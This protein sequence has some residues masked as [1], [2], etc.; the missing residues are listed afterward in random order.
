MDLRRA[1]TRRGWDRPQL[2][3]C[4]WSSSSIAPQR[5]WFGPR[6]ASAAGDCVNGGPDTGTMA[7]VPGK[8]TPNSAARDKTDANPDSM[9]PRMASVELSRLAMCRS[10]ACRPA[11]SSVVSITSRVPEPRRAS[12]EARRRSAQRGWSAAGPSWLGG[13][14]QHSSSSSQISERTG[15]RAVGPPPGQMDRGRCNGVCD[16]TRCCCFELHMYRGSGAETC[17]A[18]AYDC[19]GAMVVGPRCVACQR[20]LL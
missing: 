13:T 10:R 17:Q 20:S 6:S 7:S 16:R 15:S 4:C 5:R 1:G 3:R 2:A 14:R 19:T 9:Q 12:T 11:A 8:L 18:T